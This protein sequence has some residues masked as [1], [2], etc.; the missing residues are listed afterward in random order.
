[1]KN[2]LIVLMVAGLAVLTVCALSTSLSAIAGTSIGA[3]DIAPG[4]TVTKLGAW[5]R[6]IIDTLCAPLYAP[7]YAPSL[8]AEDEESAD[9]EG[10]AE[11]EPEP[12]TSLERTWGVALYA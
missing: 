8:Y 11:Q 6:Q 1:M 9:E 12:D 7:L 5:C 4:A 2:V 3:S 10:E